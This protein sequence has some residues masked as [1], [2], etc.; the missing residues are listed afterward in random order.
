M[1]LC[2]S[3]PYPLGLSGVCDLYERNLI[4]KSEN[5]MRALADR[6]LIP[7]ITAAQ[8]HDHDAFDALYNHYADA[9][10]RYLYARCYDQHLAEELLGE[11]WVR[12]V[13]RI[14]AFKLPESGGEIAFTGWLYRIAANLLTDH[15]RRKRPSL[16][17]SDNWQSEQPAPLELAERA[18][19]HSAVTLA[20]GTLT[21]EQREIIHLRFFEERTSAEVAA[22]TGRTTGAVK[23]LQ[24]RALGALARALKIFSEVER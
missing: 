4:F 17:L 14:G 9:L 5:P 3:R 15:H 12:V 2:A 22:L 18:E 1:R 13:E 7:L 16:R 20:L 10:F 6:A 23:S 11:L 24:H 21:E 19:A 8:R